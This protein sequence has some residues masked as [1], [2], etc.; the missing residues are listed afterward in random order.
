[1]K[2]KTWIA[3]LA[4][5]MSLTF[6]VV[7]AG[8]FGEEDTSSSTDSV[9]SDSVANSTPVDSFSSEVEESSSS[10]T[11]GSSSS[12]VEES[13]SSSEEEVHT[14]SL[15]KVEAKEATC[16]EDG[17][18]AYYT[19]EGC[20]KLF[21]DAEGA[22]ETTLDE[23][24]I[25]AAHAYV[26]ESGKEATYFEEGVKAHYTCEN[27]EDKFLLQG[28]EYIIVTDEELVIAKKTIAD[29]TTAADMDADSSDLINTV[30]AD[31]VKQLDQTAPTYVTLANEAGETVKAIYFSRT[32]AWDAATDAEN[33]CGFSEFRIPVNAAIGG[34]S[35]TYKLLDSNNETCTTLNEMDKAYGMKSYIEYKMNGEYVNVSKDTVGNICFMADG[36]W[37]EF[38]LECNQKNVEFVIV[39]IYH[40]EGELVVTNMQ[41][42]EAKHIHETTEVPETVETCTEDGNTTYYTCECGKF[43]ADAEATQ[44]IAENSWILPAHHELSETLEYDETHHYYA[45]EKCDYEERTAH[46]MSEWTAD[47]IGEKTR[48]CDCGYQETAQQTA[49]EVDFTK[50][51]YG[52]SVYSFESQVEYADRIAETTAKSLKYL[53]YHDNNV[54]KAV[55][56]VLL[57]RIDF[58]KYGQV[59]INVLFEGFLWDQQFG[60]NETELT[61]AS[62]TYVEAQ[63]YTGKLTFT[64]KDDA[65]QMKLTIC[66]KTLTQTITD[67]N[68]ISGKSS[69][70]FC[71]QAYYDRYVTL[72]NFAF[73]AP[74]D[75]NPY[76]DQYMAGYATVSGEQYDEN[77]RLI[78]L[79]ME[80]PGDLDWWINSPVLTQDYLN[81]LV[82]EKLACVTIGVASTATTN[83]FITVYNGTPNYNANA[84]CTVVLAENGGDLQFSYVDLNNGGKTVATT[85]TLTFSYSVAPQ[86]IADEIG[87]T[88]ADNVNMVKDSEGVYTISNTAGYQKDASF[89]AE[90]VNA[91]I[92]EGYDAISLKATFMG[93]DNIDQVVG[94]TA[95]LGYFTNESGSVEWTVNLIK[96]EPIHFWAQKSGATASG[97]FT[98]SQ[99]ELKKQPPF[100]AGYATV[101]GEQYDENDRI[102]GFTAEIPAGLD[103]SKGG[104]LFTASYLNKLYAKGIKTLI[105]SAES[106]VTTNNFITFYNN[107]LDYDPRDGY[108]VKLLENGGD[109]KISYVD[110]N[111]GGVTVATTLTI[112]IEYQLDP[113][114]I[115]D[116]IGLTLRGNNTISKDSENTYTI[117][118][119][120][121]YDG[122]VYFSAEQVNAWIAEGY[123]SIS[124]NV[125]F[126]A[127][128]TIDTVV[129]YTVTSSFVSDS[130]GAAAWTITLR[131]NEDVYLWAQKDGAGS[132]GAFTI[133]RVA[134]VK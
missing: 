59:T 49:E 79:T 82:S 28:E 74:E 132:T 56:K 14:H 89:T 94:W 50:N 71:S 128:E 99:V 15:T 75:V 80:I 113:Q 7:G 30:V 51:T 27:C 130:T 109:L 123:T 11:E 4:M 70:Y 45:C 69:A 24:K 65:L 120:V 112:A 104:P 9:T 1:M 121:G 118:N 117:S 93:S 42:L 116:E 134:L 66:G 81:A 8:C 127:G 115:A 52:A 105:I 107:T 86:T 88:L 33:N 34:V 131:A 21:A 36:E 68:V 53:L 29:E 48:S 23:V 76:G 110:L 57:P 67:E 90:Q 38:M 85:L 5:V 101:S 77:K 96:D 95:S 31:K 119:A 98:L 103:W 72:S 12:E 122:S 37:H 35:F 125:A 54:V 97:A 39:K 10:E 20:E 43:F 19:C 87:M 84:G 44:E 126:M 102:V 16:T 91:W 124:M 22:N 64:W 46:K 58:T 62:D 3:M 133:S 129:Y 83:N 47:H 78:G 40:F 100:T 41:T 92:E 61:N 73:I 55:H 26:E 25:A 18:S 106:T 60:L 6:G 13:S 17:Y 108:V 2:R 114:V 111:N 63:D 32:T